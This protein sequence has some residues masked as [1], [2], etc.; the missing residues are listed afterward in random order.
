MRKESGGEHVDDR[1]RRLGRS[2]RSPV[3]FFSSI[4]DAFVAP[5]NVGATLVIGLLAA[6]MAAWGIFT[7]RA[8]A[9][10]RA[11]LDLI[12]SLERDGDVIAA[13]SKFIEL[14]KSEGGLANW[15][16][17]SNENSA[18]AQSIRTVLNEFELFAIGIQRGIIDFELYK[19]WN[20]SSVIRYWQHAAPYVHILRTRLN[21]PA[22]YHEYEELVRWMKGEA[23]PKRNRF[24]G[25]WF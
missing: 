20:R 1:E 23:M 7:Q 11:T 9:R 22:I 19:R 14:A 24:I 2:Y 21:N 13:R 17:Q 8:V 15:A 25:I 5:N 3:N 18:E 12:S 4:S 10:R 16:G 6:A